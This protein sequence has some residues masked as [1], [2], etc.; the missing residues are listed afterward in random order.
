MNHLRWKGIYDIEVLY[1]PGDVVYA[2]DG[3]TY[4]SVTESLGIPPYLE[5]SGFELLAGFTISGVDGGEF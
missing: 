5:N 3:F 4:V 1:E 2:D